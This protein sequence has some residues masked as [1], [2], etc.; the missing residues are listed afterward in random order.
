VDYN[1][2]GQPLLEIVSAPDLRSVE[3]VSAYMETLRSIVLYLGIS[4][5]RME[6]GAIRFEANVSVRPVNSNEDATRVEI[7]NL[8]S[9]KAVTRSLEYEIQRQRAARLRGETILQETRLWDDVRGVTE[10]MRSKEES[11]DYR[12]FPDPDL[13]PLVID[14]DWVERTRAN[15]PELPAARRRRFVT[16]HG[17]PEYDARLLTDSREMAD[18]FE[19]VAERYPQPKAISN[20]LMG[21]AFRLL[22]E[23]GTTL[24]ESGLTPERL[25]ELLEMID[26]GAVNTNSAKQVFEEVFRTGRAPAEIVAERGL[27]LIADDTALGEIVDRVLA[28]NPKVVAEYRQGKEK[29]FTFLVGQ[30]MR[31]TQGRADPPTVNRLLRERVGPP[32]NAKKK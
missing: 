5:A 14:P 24:A 31:Q 11:H 17:L 18:F 10:P 30:V 19:A 27:G 7:K 26:Q 23:Q 20:W 29:S 15:L 25:V 3:E 22:N 12:Y 2:S 6:E 9:F 13:T 8:N 28:E 32:P 16:E 1:R 4:S 21:E